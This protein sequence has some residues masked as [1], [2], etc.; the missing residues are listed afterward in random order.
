MEWMAMRIQPRQVFPPGIN[1]F[2][3]LK[4]SRYIASPTT[5]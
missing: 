5:G 2:A 3:R 4:D 1:S